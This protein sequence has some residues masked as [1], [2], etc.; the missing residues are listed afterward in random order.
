MHDVIQDS[1]KDLTKLKYLTLGKIYYSEGDTDE[2][3]N[4]GLYGVI[5]ECIGNLT[6]LTHLDLSDTR[7]QGN[8]PQSIDKI[9]NYKVKIPSSMKDTIYKVI[10]PSSMKDT[11]YKVRY[12]LR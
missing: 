1:I 3:I 7:L 10:I 6:N 9:I 8:I 5:P 11:I 4:S 12:R 2:N